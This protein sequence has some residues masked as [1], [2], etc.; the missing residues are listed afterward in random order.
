MV[1]MEYS[2]RLILNALVLITLG[3]SLSPAQEVLQAEPAIYLRANDRFGFDLLRAAHQGSP[4]LNV[5]VSP[6]PI[7]LAFAVLADGGADP[8]SVQEFEKAFHWLDDPRVRYVAS[9]AKMVLRRFEKPRPRPM[10][11]KMP[12]GMPREILGL[13]KPEEIWL[14]TAFI[15][16][17][18][19]NGVSPDFI[20]R[21]SEDIGVPFRMIGAT[22]NQSAAIAASWDRTVPMPKIAGK[23]NDF[24]ITSSTHL[25][26][27]WAG[28]TFVGSRR[29]KR[30]FHLRS[31]EE[32]SVDFLT[33]EREGYRHAR[34]DEFE[35]A[36]LRCNEA[37]ILLVLPR[38]N[39]DRATGSEDLVAAGIS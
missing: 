25:R 22:T 5:V 10:P 7:S 29:T 27:A 17:S 11:A 16:R 30:I 33:T 14:T 3:A 35:A 34:T 8:E 4:D 9:A 1:S 21:V 19:V 28:N 24:W 6:L 23:K 13:I 37:T 18:Y 39:V 2:P 26:T 38:A 15:Y 12:G 36:E 32:I 20:N 31:T